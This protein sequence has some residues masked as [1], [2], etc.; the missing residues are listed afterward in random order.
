M[1]KIF[2]SHSSSDNESALQIARALRRNGLDVF[3]D[4]WSL[5]PGDSLVDKIQTGVADA[6]VLVVLLSNSSVRSGWVRQEINAFFNS[7]ISDRGIR[8][9][10]VLL[11]DV[12]VPPLLRDRLYVDFR[13]DPAAATAKLVQ[14]LIRI[15][16][17]RAALPDEVLI[18]NFDSGTMRPNNLGGL[19]LVY[20]ETGDPA[21]LSAT[22][23]NHGRGR[24]LRLAFDFRPST[25]VPPQFVGYATR[26]Q[27][28]NWGEFVECGYWLRF[29]VWSDGNAPSIQLEI[30]RLQT[31]P[32]EQSRQETAKWDIRLPQ[33]RVWESRSLR[34]ADIQLPHVSWDNLW[35][36]CFVLF[37]A[38]VAGDSGIVQIDNLMLSRNPN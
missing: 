4:A 14:Q 33:S 7:A 22:F 26:L 23:V 38:N 2:I 11:D 13:A 35:E 32:M 15:S 19:T 12:E 31:P 29:D 20:H 1:P 37:R 34:L 5:N 17:V 18:D 28:A 9:I 6:N 10:P 16:D 25:G 30:K 21:T 27:F 36:I 8:I 24:A 3:Y